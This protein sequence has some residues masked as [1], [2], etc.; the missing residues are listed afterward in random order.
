VRCVPSTEHGIETRQMRDAVD[1]LDLAVLMFFF[2]EILKR[3]KV[4]TQGTHLRLIK[5]KKTNN[6]KREP[7]F[8]SSAIKQASLLSLLIISQCGNGAAS[9]DLKRLILI[10][11]KR[12]VLY[13]GV[14]KS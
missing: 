12:L 2:F 5:T 1:G 3:G 6:R 10:T 4:K 11:P 9:A 14:T 7:G 13:P 8:Q